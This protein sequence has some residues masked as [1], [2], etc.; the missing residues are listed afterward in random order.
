MKKLSRGEKNVCTRIKISS[1]LLF[2]LIF[3][4]IIF[5]Q[6]FDFPV[7]NINVYATSSGLDKIFVFN[8]DN[9]PPYD[10]LFYNQ[11]S[12]GYTFHSGDRLEKGRSKYFFYP[13]TEINFFKHGTKG[14]KDKYLFTSQDKNVVG[15]VSFTEYGGMR[16]LNV[17]KVKDYPDKIDAGKYLAVPEE[18]AIV[19]GKNFK[20]VSS[21]S[22]DKF[23]LKFK[24]LFADGYFKSGGFVDL[25]VDGYND[26]VL[27]DATKKKLNY[28]LNVTNTFQL[29]KQEDISGTLTNFKVNDFDGDRVRDF[30]F[31]D[32]KFLVVYIVNSNPK[33]IRHFR[34]NVGN[35]L[36]YKFMKINSDNLTDIVTI[37]NSNN[38]KVF[39]NLGKDR[40]TKGNF[41]TKTA[42]VKTLATLWD[43][44]QRNLILLSN[45]GLFYKIHRISVVDTS[46]QILL[47]G[48]GQNNV[49][50]AQTPENIEVSWVD[51]KSYLS[52]R[53]TVSLK[54]GAVTQYRNLIPYCPDE[55]SV[56]KNQHDD[57]WFFTKYLHDKFS[58]LLKY[59]DNTNEVFI[60][61]NKI[62]SISDLL[63][64]KDGDSLKV[65]RPI[66][67][68]NRVRIDTIMLSS[69]PIE[70]FAS[71]NNKISYLNNNLDLVFDSIS[72]SNKGK[73]ES[74]YKVKKIKDLY[75]LKNNLMKPLMMEKTGRKINIIS[76]DTTITYYSSVDFTS[77]RILPFLFMNGNSKNLIIYNPSDFSFRKAELREGKSYLRFKK[78]FTKR[79]ITNFET[80]HIGNK[81]YIIFYDSTINSLV[82][83]NIL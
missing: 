17:K 76:A 38:L 52:K 18:R 59:N 2:V 30:S 33:N 62:Y 21:V 8:A 39:Y 27:Y 23:K 14:L 12:L 26:L 78:V 32:G 58:Y 13:L 28:Y 71:V 81:D 19:F 9:K 80:A 31:T 70:V 16:L 79:N 61:T 82:F 43:N 49:V 35:C 57:F 4:G 47:S 1:V 48:N 55:F 54:N 65:L 64:R 51:K 6:R 40:F 46:A 10:L 42:G 34:I 15:M 74:I 67:F 66:K 45:K 41:I 68:S 44:N 56:I 36:D 11:S 29:T 73:E 22:E 37:D 53:L 69:K 7:L 77:P 50:F 20:G 75:N 5:A 3:S 24:N 60:D 72:K 25:D 83:Q 63:I